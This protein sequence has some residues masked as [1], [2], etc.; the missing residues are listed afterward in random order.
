MG[1]RSDSYDFVVVGAGSAGCAVASGL[2]DAGVGSVLII[3]AGPPDKGWLVKA[4]L[5]GT[6]SGTTAE[7]RIADYI[8]AVP[9]VGRA[10]MDMAGDSSLSV[11]G[12]DQYRGQIADKVMDDARALSAKMGPGYAVSIEGLNMPVMW[13]RAGAAEVLLYVPYKLIIIPKP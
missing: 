6:G 1:T 3:E 12:P 9:E 7:K 11:V 2:I 5:G 13:T 4:P 8:E 10:Q